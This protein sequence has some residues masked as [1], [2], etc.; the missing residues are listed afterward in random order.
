MLC[1]TCRSVVEIVPML[2]FIA[3]LVT[4]VK[5]AHD[6]EGISWTQYDQAYRCQM[7]QTKD[8]RWSWLNPIVYTLCSVKRNVVCASCLSDSYETAFP[9]QHRAF[10]VARPAYL[11]NISSPS[12]TSLSKGGAKVHIPC[13]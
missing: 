8:L 7:A 5:C 3:Y 10:P 13:M 2:E 4:I 6:F 1:G 11:P 9:G 12:T